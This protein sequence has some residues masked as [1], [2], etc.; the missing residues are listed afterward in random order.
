MLRAVE[1]LEQ[2]VDASRTGAIEKCTSSIALIKTTKER[3]T[4]SGLR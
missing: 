2:D 3:A 4:M 1:L